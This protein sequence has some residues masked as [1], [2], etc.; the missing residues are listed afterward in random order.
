MRRPGGRAAVGAA[1]DGPNGGGTLASHIVILRYFDVSVL[2]RA[3][4]GRRRRLD[5]GGFSHMPI[6]LIALALGGFG[7]GL[8]E[9]G[10]VGLLPQVASDLGVSGPIAGYLVSVYALSVAVGALGL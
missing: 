1:G 10:I 5:D 8:T 6:G 7:I 3:P 2:V 4:G 9:F